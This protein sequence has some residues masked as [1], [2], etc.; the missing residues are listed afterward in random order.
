MGA[1]E[2]STREGDKAAHWTER[3]DTAERSQKRRENIGTTLRRIDRLEADRRRIERAL[4]GREE[5]VQDEN[6]PIHYAG[7]RWRPATIPPD[8]DAA[9]R[10]KVDLA[11]LDD[12]L[13][14]WRDLIRQAEE[15]G[16][17]LWRAADFTKGDFARF[18]GSWYEVLRVNPKTL[19]VPAFIDIRSVVTPADSPYS[20]TDRIPYDE[21]SGRK[22]GDE[23]L[24][25]LR[26]RAKGHGD[27]HAGGSRL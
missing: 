17:K 2:R 8:E 5:V 12:E 25:L 26:K 3:A 4:R 21:V 22:S 19:T 14:Y 15:R 10:M 13:A 24:A 7:Q 1:F 9:A 20:W 18:R 6:G 11:A 23:V 27:E 16:V